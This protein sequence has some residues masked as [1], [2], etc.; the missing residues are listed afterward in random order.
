MSMFTI[1]E[2]EIHL[3]TCGNCYHFK[4]VAQ[5]PHQVKGTLL[6]S[7]LE[8]CKDGIIAFRCELDGSIGDNCE[9]TKCQNWVQK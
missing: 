7:G 9:E 3:R 8:K 2:S 4:R 6:R 5:I 1:K